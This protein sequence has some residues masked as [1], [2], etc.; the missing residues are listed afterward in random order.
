M[1]TAADARLVQLF[2]AFV[3]HHRA[4]DNPLPHE[5]VPP[6]KTL[7]AIHATDNAP[8]MPAPRVVMSA[9]RALMPPP[10]TTAP[11]P[12]PKTP[13]SAPKAVVSTPRAI[14]PNPKTVVS[15]PKPVVSTPKAAVSAPNTVV[16]TPNA[17]TSTPK[18]TALAAN[19]SAPTHKGVQ[20]RSLTFNPQTISSV[21]T[22]V[23]FTPKT[24]APTPKTVAPTP[25][26]VAPTPKT[27]FMT[28][29]R[30]VPIAIVPAPAAA[31]AAAV[32][33]AVATAPTPVAE[34]L[35][36]PVSSGDDKDNDGAR[37]PQGV[38]FPVGGKRRRRNTIHDQIEMNRIYNASDFT[39]RSCEEIKRDI[40]NQFAVSTTSVQRYTSEKEREIKF[41][42][43]I[44]IIHLYESKQM[45]I[46]ELADYYGKQYGT[47]IAILEK[48]AIIALNKAAAQHWRQKYREQ[49]THLDY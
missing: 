44:D 38:T 36:D 8:V 9:P 20:P 16:P 10:A 15:T 42:D 45:T 7:N 47:V 24:V 11:T 49:Q 34:G 6:P 19:A 21:C 12:A 27:A 3:E 46:R 2:A 23:T 14:I 32:A 22:A 48:D 31:P 4:N 18:E 1:Q 41:A 43:E 30:P 35:G 39:K 29:L 5:T 37:Y 40:A 25:M 13:V 33:T 28:V 17:V 26:T